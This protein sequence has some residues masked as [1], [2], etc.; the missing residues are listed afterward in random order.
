MVLIFTGNNE[1]PTY[2]SLKLFNGS[3]SAGALYVFDGTGFH[4]ICD[5]GF[6]T[7]ELTV[8][9]QQLGYNTGIQVVN[10]SL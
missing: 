9:C 4:P 1:V 5:N 8:A 2:G 3:G 10:N 6:G 7:N